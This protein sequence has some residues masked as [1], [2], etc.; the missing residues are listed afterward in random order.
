M[1]VPYNRKMGEIS[2]VAVCRLITQCVDY[3]LS[4][5]SY[6]RASKI[7][8]WLPN[9]TWPQNQPTVWKQRD[10]HPVTIDRPPHL[11]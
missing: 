1:T 5:S 2:V 8:D 10:L 7:G 4:G 11:V 3:L 6:M 9:W